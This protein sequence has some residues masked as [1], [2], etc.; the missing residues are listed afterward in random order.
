MSIYQDRLAKWQ[1][2]KV[3]GDHVQVEGKEPLGSWY[4]TPAIENGR[5][6]I[7]ILDTGHM[8]VNTRVKWEG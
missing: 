1:N 3:T 2:E 8:L 5:V 6:F 7:P 4:S